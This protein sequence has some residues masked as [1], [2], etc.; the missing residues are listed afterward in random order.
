M[1]AFYKAAMGILATTTLAAVAFAASQDLPA[2]DAKPLVEK[3]CTACHDAKNIV[4]KKASK[5][6]WTDVVKSMQSY[7]AVVSD[8]DFPTIVNYLTAHFG[9]GPAPSGGGGA[10]ASKAD[11][12]GL[13]AG[14]GR[15]MVAT[16]C[17]ACHDLEQVKSQK[18]SKDEWKDLVTKMVSYGANLDATQVTTVTDY[19]SKAYP[20]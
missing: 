2:D 19:L 11:E 20:K 12:Y 16:A 3:T 10:T 5:D 14:E 13:P 9:N 6:E 15:E 4:Q 17:T 1:R 18:I 8:K 7:G